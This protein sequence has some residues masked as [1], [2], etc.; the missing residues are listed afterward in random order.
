[1]RLHARL[2]DYQLEGPHSV[3]ISFEVDPTSLPGILSNFEELLAF[4]R[5]DLTADAQD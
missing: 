5:R 4:P 3:A 1:V 2:T